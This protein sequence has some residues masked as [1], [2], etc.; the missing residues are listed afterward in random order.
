MWDFQD[1]WPREKESEKE[2]GYAGRRSE[3]MPYLRRYRTES[4]AAMQEPGDM[5]QRGLRKQFQGSK[6]GIQDLI[7][8][9][10][11]ILE[12]DRLAMWKIGSG[13]FKRYIKI[14]RLCL[15]HSGTQNIGPGSK[16]GCCH[17]S[18]YK[19][20]IGHYYKHIDLTSLQVVCGFAWDSFGQKFNWM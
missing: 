17:W 12:G 8:N 11:G 4:K 5:G 9:N 15:C 2:I 14:Y 16:E 10:S 3:K 20:L 7:R 13:S 18:L 6:D 1:F 19:Y